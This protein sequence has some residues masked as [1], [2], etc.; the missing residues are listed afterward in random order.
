LTATGAN[1]QGK[2]RIGSPTPEMATE[3]VRRCKDAPAESVEC[4]VFRGLLV[5]ELTNLL[6]RSEIAKDRRAVEP[7]L[8][9]LALTEEPDILVAACRVLGRFPDTPSV[10]PKLI[11]LL[12]DSPY[13][14]V[15]RKAAAVLAENPDPQVQYLGKLWGD[16]H[17]GLTAQH[18][19]D[20]YPDFP[21]H[22]AKIGFPTY[23]GATWLSAADSDRSVGWSTADDPAKVASWFA[24]TLKT[25]VLDGNQWSEVQREQTMLAVQTSVNPKTMTRMQQLMEKAASGKAT[26]AENEEYMKLAE[27]LGDGQKN[28]DAALNNSITASPLVQTLMPRDARWIV[29]RKK[30][31]RISQ[32]VIVFPMPA[33]R[34]TAIAT[35]WDLSDFPS[36]WPVE[37]K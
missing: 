33:L 27:S 11:P 16:G 30:G 3:F 2:F 35:V 21:D 28:M 7:A 24:A 20:E 8:A 37:T 22:Y 36:A 26:A 1:A 5:F 9:A 17:S 12:L 19:S 32:L 4:E 13:I 23:P 34:R 10:A 18:P 14:E 15:Q 6:T 31:E 25:T 29:A